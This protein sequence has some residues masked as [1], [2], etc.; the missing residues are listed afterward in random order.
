[1]HR[2][3]RVDSLDLFRPAAFN[4]QPTGRSHGGWE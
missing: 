3:G 4:S 2:S 1:M